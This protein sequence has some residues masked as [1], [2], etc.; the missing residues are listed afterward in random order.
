MKTGAPR[1]LWHAGTT[2]RALIVHAHCLELAKCTMWRVHIHARVHQPTWHLLDAVC[3]PHW[4]GVVRPGRE[5]RTS[6]QRGAQAAATRDLGDAATR[7]NTYGN[8]RN[9]GHRP[10]AAWFSLRL[11]RPPRQ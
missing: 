11:S 5:S 1:D 9:S 10:D 7:G 3:A 6:T 8:P 2:A 4:L